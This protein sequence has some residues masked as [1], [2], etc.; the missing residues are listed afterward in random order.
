MAKTDLKKPKKGFLDGYKTYDDSHGRGNV[1]KWRASWE[2]M[3]GDQAQEIIAGDD[4]LSIMGFTSLPTM[5]E[6]MVRFRELMQVHHPDHGGDLE[7]AKKING[8]WTILRNLLN[9]RK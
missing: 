7:T 4:P 6:L 1:H 3:S 9:L 8:A 2:D 5:P